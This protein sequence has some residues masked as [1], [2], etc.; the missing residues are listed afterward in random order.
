[1]RSQW[2]NFKGWSFK[3]S[4]PFYENNETLVFAFASKIAEILPFGKTTK[5]STIKGGKFVL[6]RPSVLVC[7]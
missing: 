5:M 3:K 7:G 2:K 1:M 4:W 6:V